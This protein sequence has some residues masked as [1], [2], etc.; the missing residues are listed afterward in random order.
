[1]ATTTRKRTKKKASRKKISRKA[2]TKKTARKKVSKKKTARKKTSRKK[3]SKKK[4]SKKKAATKRASKKKVT[5]KK[6][7]RNKGSK[8]KAQRR[9]AKRRS[10]PTKAVAPTSLEPIDFARLEMKHTPESLGAHHA[11]MTPLAGEFRATVRMWMGPGDPHVSTGVMVNTWDLGGRFLKQVYKGNDMEG[12]FPNFEG[13][14]YMGYNDATGRWE[15][16]WLDNAA[17]MMHIDEGEYDESVGHWEMSGTLTN[18]ENGLVMRKRSVFR[19]LDNDRHTMESWFAA[20]DGPEFK[21][22]EIEFERV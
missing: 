9:S 10:S 7:A 16:V 6:V 8:K 3:V 17:T 14:G 1:M 22:M 19:V 11:R 2:S 4:A 5:R 21:S 15:G 18:P 12:P 13:R 20:P